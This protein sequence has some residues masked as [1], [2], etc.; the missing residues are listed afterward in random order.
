MLRVWQKSSE[1]S[2]FFLQ[3][4]WLGWVLDLC[5]VVKKIF[6]FF[7]RKKYFFCA[8]EHTFVALEMIESFAFKG[9]IVLYGFSD[10][11]FLKKVLVFACLF[12][13][14]IPIY[15]YIYCNKFF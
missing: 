7:I 3:L 13:L 6:P 10:M 8:R 4:F 12:M 15:I 11:G 1:R 5:Q 9:N 14:L 2:T